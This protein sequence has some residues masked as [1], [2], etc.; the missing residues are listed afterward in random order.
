METDIKSKYCYIIKLVYHNDNLFMA[1]TGENEKLF[2]NTES[3]MVYND[4]TE[5]TNA[6]NAAGWVLDDEIYTCDFDTIMKWCESEQGMTN[7]SKIIDAWNLLSD[8]SIF[9]KKPFCGDSKCRA[10]DA[11]Y[12]KLFYSIE[13]P[14]HHKNQEANV[15]WSST[16]IKLLKSI[17]LHGKTKLDFVISRNL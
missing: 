16:E 8:I 3:K 6:I 7:Y 12:N 11:V 13:L 15:G 5:C 2:I 14:A 1:W 4:I 10:I 9:I 17:L